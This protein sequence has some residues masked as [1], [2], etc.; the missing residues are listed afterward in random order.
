MRG[1][2][3]SGRARA[4]VARGGPATLVIAVAIG[5]C[6]TGPPPTVPPTAPTIEV[7]VLEGLDG[8]GMFPIDTNARGQV[9]GAVPVP[10]SNS[11][12]APCCGTARR[13]T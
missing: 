9:A 1:A 12:T 11:G 13:S 7:E 4:R 6:Q 8:Q 10:G 5:A 3:A 2:V